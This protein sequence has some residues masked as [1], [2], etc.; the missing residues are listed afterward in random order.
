MTTLHLRIA[1]LTMPYKDKKVAVIIPA[2]NEQGSIADVVNGIVS[3]VSDNLEKR[4]IE[5]V[6]VCDNHSSDETASRAAQAGAKVVYESRKGYGAAC[7]KA[8]EALDRTIDYVVFV[9][10]DS[11]VDPSEVILLIKQLEQGIDLV[12]GSRV[13]D[14]LEK[15]ALGPHQRMGNEMASYLI[16]KIWK[17]K[18]TDLGPFR[19]MQYSS[20]Q[21]I[22]MQDVAFGW[23]AEMQ[24][25]VIQSGLAYKEIEVSTRRRVGKSKIS[26]T[27]SGTVGAAVGIFSKIFLLY[28]NQKEF[29]QSNQIQMALKSKS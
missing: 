11:S 16:R 20:L 25:K 2:H 12:V 3:L 9:D 28:W 21:A 18:V 19:A 7:L 8:I 22:N 4:L 26:G 13:N 24:V 17:Q 10:G 5:E 29:V 23:T 27:I 14:R 1:A 15:G 6:I